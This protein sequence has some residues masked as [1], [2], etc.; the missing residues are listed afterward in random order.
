MDW[1]RKSC[2][3]AFCLYSRWAADAKLYNSVVH[4]T[5]VF[6]PNQHAAGCRPSTS[7]AHGASQD[8]SPSPALTL[9][10]LH[11]RVQEAE[12]AKKQA[13]QRQA[14]KRQG[15]TRGRR[16]KELTTADHALEVA[17]A[18]LRIALERPGE[19][20]REAQRPIAGRN[21]SVPNYKALDGGGDQGG[22]TSEEM[23][24]GY[25]GKR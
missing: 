1:L 10:D 14:E 3:P 9:E 23:G 19:Q 7:A 18:K 15:Q 11:K 12:A 24:E 8:R 22:S 16:G 20:D 4:G 25:M 5:L 21:R 2:L 17:K 13:Q 6:I